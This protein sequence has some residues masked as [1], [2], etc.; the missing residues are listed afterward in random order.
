MEQSR[1]IQPWMLVSAA[2]LAPAFLGFV[3]SVGLSHIY[4]EPFNLAAA[5]FYSTDWLLYALLTP[6]VFILARRW[7]ITRPH[8]VSRTLLHI[9]LSIVFSALWAAGG[10]LLKLL[11]QPD[12]FKHGVGTYALGWFMGT[13]PFGCAVYLGMVG[14]EHAIRYFTEARARE[15]QLARLAEQLTSARLSALKAQLNPHFL[16]NA[17]NT[18]TVLMREG[19]TAGATRVMEQLSDVLRLTLSRNNENEV[20]LEDEIELVR[21][22]LEVERARFSDRLRPEFDIDNDTLF[23]AIPSFAL[24]H[25]VENAVRHGIA[26]RSDARR[27]TI[28]AHRDGEMLEI[29]VTDDGPGIAAGAAD[30]DGHGLANTRERLRTLYGDRASLEVG[31]APGGGTLARMRI[32][33]HEIPLRAGP[34]VSA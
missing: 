22:Y 29:T 21:Q 24:Q 23:A 26:R 28:A 3:T 12:S 31:A 13:L 25:L 34:S 18:I 19:D 32:P 4:G 10:T 20:T 27:I 2:W 15:V 33:F 6:G 7:P 11:L 9:A 1:R 16:F 30:A 8:L 17:L 14:V 5:V